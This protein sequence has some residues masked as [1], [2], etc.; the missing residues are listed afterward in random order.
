M[1][2]AIFYPVNVIF[3]GNKYYSTAYEHHLLV[4]LAKHFKST[5]L[6]VFHKY[7]SETDSD[8]IE[9]DNCNM[10][11]IG[12]GGYVEPKR[13]ITKLGWIRRIFEL[14]YLFIK[15]TKLLCSMKRKWDIILIWDPFITNQY[16]Y[17]INRII[18]IPSVLFLGAFHEKTILLGAKNRNTI[19]KISYYVKFIL[20]KVIIPIMVKNTTTVVAG[21]EL[22]SIY[23]KI[24]KDTYKIITSTASKIDVDMNSV[25]ERKY[26]KNSYTLLNVSR[27][28]P[29]KGIEYLIKSVGILSNKYDLRIIL[30]GPKVNLGYYEYLKREYRNENLQDKVIFTGPINDR[31]KLMEYYTEADIFILPSLSE[32]LPKVLP[33]AM[34]KGL[35]IIASRIGGIPEIVKDGENGILVSPN[36]IEELAKAIKVLLDDSELRKR[37]GINSLNRAYKYTIERQMSNFANYIKDSY[38]NNA[39]KK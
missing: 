24:N 31:D 11:I 32:G 19:H 27:I 22:L 13:L 4:E 34:S 8:M 15:I 7:S 28:T 25:K 6:I 21:E 38:L 14:N 23:K 37:M 12:I 20:Y 36:N 17:I 39:R 10:N 29:E 33:E 18:R 30:I 16:L 3:D 26:I 5:D 2:L 35:P 1:R 9:I